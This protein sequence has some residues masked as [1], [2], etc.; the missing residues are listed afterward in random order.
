ANLL[1]VR[2]AARTHEFASREALGAARS[3]LARLVLIALGL[4]T[5]VG[6]L[7]G[8]ALAALVVA[9]VSQIIPAEYTTLGTPDVGPR[10]VAFAAASGLAIMVAGLVPGWAAWRTTPDGRRLRRARRWATGRDCLLQQRAAT[11][12][13]RHPR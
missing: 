4:L 6:V 8:V 2:A 12:C 9:F 10:V 13:R 7:G 1:F 3:D 5:G 11:I